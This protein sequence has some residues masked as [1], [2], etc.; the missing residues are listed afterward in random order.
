MAVGGKTKRA[1]RIE[2]NQERTEKRT[3]GFVEF[4]FAIEY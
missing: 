3:K 2:V 4:S 1:K